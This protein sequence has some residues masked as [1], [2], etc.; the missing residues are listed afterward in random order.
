[1][2][3]PRI[4]SARD[5]RRLDEKAISDYGIEQTLLM[6]NAAIAARNVI[7]ERWSI[8]GSSILVI[9][10]TGSNGG[11]GFA[12]ARHL[13]VCGAMVTVLI[14]GNTDKISGG[15]KIN[16]QIIKNLSL[17][18]CMLEPGL[19][20]AFDFDSFDLVVD[21]LFGTG[22]SRNIEGR[23]AELI[24]GINGSSVPVLSLDIPS[25]IHADSGEILGCAVKADATIS[26]GILK[27]GNLLYPG[28]AACGKLYYGRISFPPEVVEDESI[29]FKIN[30]PPALPEREPTGHKGSFGKVLV[31]GGS[32]AYRGAPLLAA[33]AA[34]YSGA[35]Y[36]R[37]AVPSG[38]AGEIF[39]LLPEAVYLEMECSG[40]LE[41]DNK[42]ALL[43]QAAQA[44]AVVLGSGISTAAPAVQLVREL[45]PE[46]E[47]PLL[48]DGD[49]LSALASYE[50]LSKSR[51]YPS[52]LTPHPGEMARLLGLS[53][54]EVELR[55]TESAAEA[56]ER[57]QAYIALKGPHTI[58]SRPTG[59]SWL[60]LTG[61]TGMGSAG[62]GDVLAGII[63][64]FIAGSLSAEEAIKLGVYIHGLAGDI[65]AEALGEVSITA[66]NIIDYLPK[67]IKIYPERMKCNPYGGR[68]EN[69]ELRI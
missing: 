35:G 25:G 28:Y 53:I 46:I 57:Y 43:E 67:A 8:D 42:A 4:A 30:L 27:K 60:N 6:E 40:I 13:H 38:I 62:T 39:P 55:R 37:L 64:A 10:G 31:I 63:S 29:R 12:L 18:L 34:F 7:Q 54:G 56:A 2:N 47:S 33:K 52:I 61:N 17:P 49:A 22:L 51:R 9:C 59:E 36:V 58:I 19:L 48:I 66:G 68:I 21:A 20:S 14:A 50:E 5:A 15:A 65:A 1:M 41:P 45:I 16:Y 44:D 24:E 69:L 3:A 23:L 32:R 11:D 26:F